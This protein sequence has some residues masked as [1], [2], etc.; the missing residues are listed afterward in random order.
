MVDSVCSGKCCP[1][2][3]WSICTHTFAVAAVEILGVCVDDLIILLKKNIAKDMVRIA[4]VAGFLPGSRPSRSFVMIV[5]SI[6]R[7]T[8][9][10]EEIH[11]HISWPYFERM[12]LPMHPTDVRVAE[13][14]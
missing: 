5:S 8:D 6:G 10:E 3:A 14:W 13:P 9:L 2:L 1:S 7:I 12:M 11:Q 4:V